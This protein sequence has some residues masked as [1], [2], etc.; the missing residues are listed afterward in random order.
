[1]NDP[2]VPWMKEVLLALLT[3]QT[4]TIGI[5]AGLASGAGVPAQS[6]REALQQLDALNEETI[7]SDKGRHLV[8][9][10]LSAI[11]DRFSP[12]CAG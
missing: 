12:S 1:M 9:Q 11:Y 10:Q 4:N 5:L 2:D 3:Y 6:I 8:S 7:G